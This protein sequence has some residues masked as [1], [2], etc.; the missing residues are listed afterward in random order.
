MNRRWWF[1]GVGG[2]GG[3]TIRR[4]SNPLNR[5]RNLHTYLDH[6]EEEEDV[7]QLW[8]ERAER[9]GRDDENQEEKRTRLDCVRTLPTYG[10]TGQF[11]GHINA[12]TFLKRVTYYGPRQEYITSGSDSGP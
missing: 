8:E 1:A 11:G 10:H 3:Y 2:G 6:E 5:Y 9:E 4:E 7:Q 12:R